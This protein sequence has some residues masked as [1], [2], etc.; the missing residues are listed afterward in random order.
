M[1]EQ[2]IKNQKEVIEDYEKQIQELKEVHRI[3]LEQ[4]NCEEKIK[5]EQFRSREKELESELSSIKSTYEDE[6]IELRKCCQDT[7]Q[8]Q[9]NLAK[10]DAL[11]S[12]QQQIQVRKIF[13]YPKVYKG[14]PL[15]T[16]YS[17]IVQLKVHRGI[18]IESVLIIF[19]VDIALIEDMHCLN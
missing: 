14:C 17:I 18:N 13:L 19:I 7:L 11:N 8:E 6:L 12:L 15:R 2:A 10:A 3:E 9:V 4:Y 16:L 5:W 1:Q